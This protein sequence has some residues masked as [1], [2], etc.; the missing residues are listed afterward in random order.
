MLRYPGSK[1][2][3]SRL[4]VK[5][6]LSNPFLLTDKV[7][8]REP[9]FGSGSVGIEL[10]KQKP[11]L[12]SIWINDLDSNLMSLWDSIINTPDELIQQISDFQ[13]SLESYESIKKHDN[14][15]LSK[16]ALH[17]LTYS[18]LGRMGSCLGGRKQTSEYKIDCRWNADVLIKR[19]NEYHQLLSGL[20][21][22]STNLDFEDVI[23]D[24]SQFSVLY[25]DPP[26]FKNGQ[27]LY[28]HSF[29]QEDHSRLAETL[30]TVS[31]THLTLPTIYSV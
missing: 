26:Y 10:L 31:Y 14:N 22:K 23:L 27:Q 25:L 16:L 13:P 17:Q 7:E 15:S 20:N 18:G 6:L 29:T 2:R 4:I 28:Q 30:K 3:I 1:S 11:T 5:A 24:E 21:V 9:F 19:V 12:K 8:Y